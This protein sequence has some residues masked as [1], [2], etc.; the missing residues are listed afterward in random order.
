MEDKELYFEFLDDLRDSGEM[1]VDGAISQ[2]AEIFEVSRDFAINL[3]T[4]WAVTL[5]ERH[6]H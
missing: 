2:V 6:K 3:L 5:A 1:N 4:E